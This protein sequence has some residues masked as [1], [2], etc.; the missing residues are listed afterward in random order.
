VA[1]KQVASDHGLVGIRP[2]PTRCGENEPYQTSF[3]MTQGQARLN[4]KHLLADLFFWK[5]YR[6]VWEI[7][8]HEDSMISIMFFWFWNPNSI[9]DCMRTCLPT[10]GGGPVGLKQCTMFVGWSLS[11]FFP[12]FLSVSKC[13]PTYYF[14]V[15]IWYMFSVSTCR[16]K[17]DLGVCMTLVFAQRMRPHSADFRFKNVFGRRIRWKSALRSLNLCTSTEVMHLDPTLTNM[18]VS[19]SYGKI[20][21]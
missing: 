1:R 9:T 12:E 10:Y 21:C 18:Q 20:K 8:L 17:L 7:G 5:K 4:T 19:N 11:C 16:G 6:N 15:R 2:R 13:R 14:S 3:E